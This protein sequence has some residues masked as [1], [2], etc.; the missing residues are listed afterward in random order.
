MHSDNFQP[1]RCER[2]AHQ[3]L[4]TA[5]FKIVAGNATEDDRAHYLQVWAS[6]SSEQS[7]D[8]TQ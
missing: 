6:V 4:M 1:S 2:Q 7:D 8:V 5:F 3:Q